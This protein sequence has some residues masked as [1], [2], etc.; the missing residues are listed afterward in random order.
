[1]AAISNTPSQND[2][3]VGFLS[4]EDEPDQK[5]SDF[6]GHSFVPVEEPIPGI[7]RAFENGIKPHTKLDRYLYQIARP[8]LL[9]KSYDVSVRSGHFSGELLA[10]SAPSIL[11]YRLT[12]HIPVTHIQGIVIPFSSAK[13]T[14]PLPIFFPYSSKLE[15]STSRLEQFYSSRLRVSVV[16][17]RSNDLAR[18]IGRLQRIHISS[19]QDNPDGPKDDVQDEIT[20]K[21]FIAELQY[22]I[23]KNIRKIYRDFFKEKNLTPLRW[24][25]MHTKKDIPIYFGD[26]KIAAYGL[27]RSFAGFLMEK[28]EKGID[29]I[30]ELDTDRLKYLLDRIAPIRHIHLAEDLFVK[31]CKKGS[32]EHLQH[33]GELLGRKENFPF[34]DTLS[35]FNG[36]FE[37]F[38]RDLSESFSSL[39]K[40]A[41]FRMKREISSLMMQLGQEVP[42]AKLSAFIN[43]LIQIAIISYDSFPIAKMFINQVPS[44]ISVV[45]FKR[46]INYLYR[47]GLHMEY[48]KFG[49]WLI[50]HVN[51]E[52]VKRCKQLEK[53]T[54][55][56]L[57]KLSL[58][59]RQPVY[60]AIKAEMK[61]TDGIEAWYWHLAGRH[62]PTPLEKNVLEFISFPD[63]ESENVS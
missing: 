35:I 9:I 22:K 28:F 8:I 6:E 5:Y 25:Q 34:L 58:M 38:K 62:S 27:G 7:V 47:L 32:K 24:V 45:T 3:E 39:A 49:E 26:G 29:G 13:K 37:L 15:E 57:G 59:Q 61:K 60:Q 51:K 48:R 42:N 18:A 44:Q 4:L 41:V 12:S 50:D 46:T 11:S 63:V 33:L 52:I 2:K 43:Q 14:S 36:L 55:L 17:E 56:D 20:E 19:R 16:D 54:K 30:H 1:M 23:E 10:S 40:I 31:L 53:E 21:R